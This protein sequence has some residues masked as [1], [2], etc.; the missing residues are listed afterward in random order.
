MDNDWIA[1]CAARLR[2]TWPTLAEADLEDAAR[3]LHDDPKLRAMQPEQ[4]A[5]AWLRLGA[6]AS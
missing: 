6:L 4:A 1:R 3:A 5:V 2:R